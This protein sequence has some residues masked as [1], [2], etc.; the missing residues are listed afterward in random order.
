M[1][2]YFII[3]LIGVVLSAWLVIKIYQ[4]VNLMLL[5]I[6]PDEDFNIYFNDLI[7]IIAA[8]LLSWI[9]STIIVVLTLVLYVPKNLYL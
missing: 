7:F 5:N 1:N 2:V 9:F 3:Y 6:D 8:S 4:Q